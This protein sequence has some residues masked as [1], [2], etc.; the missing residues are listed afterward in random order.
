MMTYGA[1]RLRSFGHAL[2]GGM[3]L[4][5]TQPNARIHLVV[6]LVVVTAGAGW[7]ISPGE[8]TLVVLACG[9]VWLTE[10]LNTALEFLADEVSLERRDGIK[11]AKDVAAFAVLVSALAAVGIGV[12]VFGP[13]ILG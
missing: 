3:L 5:K 6:T 2:R 13:R 7:R 9:L 10:A 4:L 8:W 1:A 12:A 11:R